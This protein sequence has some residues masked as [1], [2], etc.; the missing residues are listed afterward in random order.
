MQ[1]L[2]QEKRRNSRLN[3]S[4]PLHYQVRGTREFGNTL[5][6]DI[7]SGGLSFIADRF[8]K[9]QTRVVLDVNMPIGSINTIGMVKWTGALSCF[10]KYQVGLEFIEINPKDK[11]FIS[12]YI[13]N[14]L[15]RMP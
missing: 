13:D 3:I 10:D 8:I 14:C 7:S 1:T 9:P 11:I 2:F 12:D 4:I 6:R 15:L 5:T